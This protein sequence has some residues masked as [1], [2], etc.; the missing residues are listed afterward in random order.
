MVPDDDLVKFSGEHLFYEITMLYQ[1]TLKLAKSEADPLCGNALIESFGIHSAIILDFMLN[2]KDTE[3]D[4][5]ANHYIRDEMAWKKINSVY[6]K[7]LN[8]I[9]RRR[10]KE[11]AHLSYERLKVTA[12]TKNWSFIAIA[13]EI[14]DLVD[15]FIDSARPNLLHIKVKTLK[16]HFQ[17]HPI[18]KGIPNFYNLPLISKPTEGDNPKRGHNAL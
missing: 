7:K 12:D 10:N 8:F 4:A 3:D 1:A 11:L 18:C 5:I 14:A 16:G 15:S 6:R 2:N 9:Y 17:N 13:R